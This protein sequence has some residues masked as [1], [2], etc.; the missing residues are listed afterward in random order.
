MQYIII[1]VII[2]VALLYTNGQQVKDL[3]HENRM[4]MKNVQK[5]QVE[6]QRLNMR[7][8]TIIKKV[9]PKKVP[10]QYERRHR[11]IRIFSQDRNKLLFP[12][13]AQFEYILPSKIKNIESLELSNF[14][15][16]R[17]Q[18][19]IDK[20][21]DTML[22]RNITSNIRHL[23]KVPHGHYSITSYLA[24]INS[25]FFINNMSLTFTFDTVAHTVT[26]TN[27]GVNFAYNIL[28]TTEERENS[29]FNL[30]GFLCEDFTLAP[31][32]LNV[33][34]GESIT[35]TGRVDMFGTTNLMMQAKEVS[36]GYD[37]VTIASIN[38]SNNV[39]TTYENDN[40]RP[41]RIISPLLKLTK[42]SLSITF[43]PAYKERRLYE[44]NGIEYSMV[45]EAVTL[46]KKMPFD[47]IHT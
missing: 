31:G 28:Y 32:I 19:V 33:S 8:M 38:V 37:D 21:N 13:S 14:A 12:N 6:N 17:S 44:F 2:I 30:I 18:K 47:Q 45:L 20:H 26:L 41:R 9:K 23:I 35:G 27:T 40:L 36:Y 4:T 43:Q 7:P 39:I 15:M 22:I 24:K 10:E 42:L 5:L 34:D 25:E 29:N 3:K 16:T 46:E 11:F 1:L